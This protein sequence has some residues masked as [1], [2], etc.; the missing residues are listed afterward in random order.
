MT[1][2]LLTEHHLEFL[3]LKRGCTGSSESTHVMSKCPLLE[4]TCRGSNVSI[5]LPLTLCMLG[6]LSCICC[7]LLNFFKNDLKKFFQ[8][9]YQSVKLFGSRSGPT[10]YRMLVLIWVQTVCKGYQQTTKVCFRRCLIKVFPVCYSDK[11]FVHSSP[12]NQH[13]IWEPF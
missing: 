8:E 7:L 5:H 4:I 6:N 10:F 12:D 9:H 2:K 13:F 3:S 11:S 1:V